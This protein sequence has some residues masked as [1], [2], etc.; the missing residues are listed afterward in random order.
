MVVSS[1]LSRRVFL[2]PV[3]IKTSF[4]L[5]NV[6]FDLSFPSVQYI[7]TVVPFRRPLYTFL[8]M[9]LFVF[10]PIFLHCGKREEVS[11]SCSTSFLKPRPSLP[12]SFFLSP[13]SPGQPALLSSLLRRSR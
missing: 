12:S 3:I 2:F 11:R 10:V 1:S 6:L 4:T 9:L 8:V 13:Q 7:S 5:S